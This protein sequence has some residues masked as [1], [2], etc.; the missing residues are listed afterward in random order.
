MEIKMIRENLLNILTL[1]LKLVSN[2]NVWQSSRLSEVEK[3][4]KLK[5][6][7]RRRKL[8]RIHTQKLLGV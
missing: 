1:T 2:L 7:E 4:G 8:I 3:L 6:Q 5:T